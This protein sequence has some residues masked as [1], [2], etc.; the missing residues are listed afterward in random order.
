MTRGGVSTATGRDTSSPTVHRRSSTTR[1][2]MV[3]AA[4][5]HESNDELW[6]FAIA[7]GGSP[8]SGNAGQVKS[9]N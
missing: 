4:Q 5:E 8:G 9:S 1:R 6:I 7:V 3:A 2:T